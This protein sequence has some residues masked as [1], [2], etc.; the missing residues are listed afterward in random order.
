MGLFD[1]VQMPTSFIGALENIVNSRYAPAF[2][3]TRDC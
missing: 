2:D 1:G 3:A